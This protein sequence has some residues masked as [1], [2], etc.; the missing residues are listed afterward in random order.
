M[1]ATNFSAQLGHKAR[2]RAS[3]DKIDQAMTA[4]FDHMEQA[5]RELLQIVRSF[6]EKFPPDTKIHPTGACVGFDK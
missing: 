4:K 3:I 5:V 6:A 2:L 1:V